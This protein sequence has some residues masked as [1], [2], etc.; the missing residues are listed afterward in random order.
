MSTIEL[1]VKAPRATRN[2][3]PVSV[4][5]TGTEKAP[6]TRKAVVSNA[7]IIKSLVRDVSYVTAATKQLTQLRGSKYDMAWSGLKTN[8]IATTYT[9]IKEA[10]NAV[11]FTDLGLDNKGLGGLKSR[12]TIGIARAAGLY[13]KN[14]IGENGKRI[15][16]SD[17]TNPDAMFEVKPAKEYKFDREAL[18][19]AMLALFK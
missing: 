8:G 17:V 13:K 4:P 14:I 10:V 1:K 19:T 15:K 11:D 12:I 6:R 16:L 9:A 3:K 2:S 5:A 18:N 7:T